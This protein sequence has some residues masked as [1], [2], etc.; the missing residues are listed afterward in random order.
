MNEVIQKE[1]DIFVV[2][3]AEALDVKVIPEWLYELP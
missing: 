1:N 2:A 3:Y